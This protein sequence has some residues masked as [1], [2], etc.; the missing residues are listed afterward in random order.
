MP[1]GTKGK[2]ISILYAILYTILG[3]SILGSL[4]NLYP[5]IMILLNWAWCKTEYYHVCY[6][7]VLHNPKSSP[8]Q[9]PTI[10]MRDNP[11]SKHQHCHC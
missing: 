10:V 11:A 4:I 9:L 2:V 3:T 1:K 5:T 7:M 8:T 6:V